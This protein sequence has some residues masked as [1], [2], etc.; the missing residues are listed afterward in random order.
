MCDQEK[1]AEPKRHVLPLV[2]KPSSLWETRSWLQATGGT[3]ACSWAGHVHGHGWL[4]GGAGL[5]A[6][7][8][9]GPE[10]RGGEAGI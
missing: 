10:A 4:V 3:R 1:Q 7:P 6:G 8:A 2:A 9:R 5:W